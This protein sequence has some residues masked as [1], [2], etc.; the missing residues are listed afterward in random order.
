MLTVGV[1]GLSHPVGMWIKWEKNSRLVFCG[2]EAFT[3]AGE[4]GCGQEGRVPKAF[5]RAKQGQG[6][7]AEQSQWRVKCGT[8]GGGANDGD[9]HLSSGKTSV[10]SKNLILVSKKAE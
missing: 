2:S 9:N 3:G 7:K 4:C 5:Q 8:G 1:Q 10:M 6:E